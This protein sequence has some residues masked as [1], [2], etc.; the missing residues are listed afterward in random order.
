[1]D[2]HQQIYALNKKN[3]VVPVSGQTRTDGTYPGTLRNVDCKSNADSQFA[4]ACIREGSFDDIFF[5]AYFFLPWRL[6]MRRDGPGNA[7]FCVCSGKA[8]AQNRKRVGFCMCVLA[9]P[10]HRIANGLIPSHLSR[11]CICVTR[12][13]SMRVRTLRSNI[14]KKRNQYAIKDITIEYV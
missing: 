7:V 14:C 10:R 11:N 1:M 9:M 12:G 13:T 3:C 2:I 4:S 6:Q 8:Q 5:S